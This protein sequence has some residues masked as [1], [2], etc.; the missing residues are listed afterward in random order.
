METVLL[1]LLGILVIVAGFAISI[2]LHEV[3]H[4]V[5]A[6]L[7]GVKVTQ[8]MIGFG[9]TLFSRKAGETEYGVKAVP[10]GGYIAMIGMYPPIEGEK[11]RSGSTGFFQTLMQDARD[12]SKDQIAGDD[13]RT[14]Y[15]LP[16][17]KKVIVM[18]GGP[19]M[20][21][22]LGILFYA[23]LFVGI[24][25]PTAATTTIQAVN[26]C[27]IVDG[28]DRTT[29]TD[30]DPVAPALAGGIEP[31]DRVVA[32]DGQR[33]TGWDQLSELIREN[34][35]DTVSMTVVRDGEEMQLQVTPMT[36]ARIVYDEQTGE[37]VIGA[38]GQPETEQVGFLGIVPTAA[39][40]PQPVTSVLPA[41]GQNI[42]QVAGIIVNLPQR[43][44]DTAVAAF[45]GGERD[46]E[47]PVSVIGVGRLAGEI[48]AS[49]TL[50]WTDRIA[51]L[52]GILAALNIGLAIFNLIPLPPL[53]GGHVIVALWEGL[54][55]GIAKLFR[56]PPP[57]PF[58]TAKLI[59]V[60]F[61][62]VLLFGGMSLLLFYADIVN[63][64]NLLG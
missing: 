51:T 4:L 32:F 23:I 59:P 5:P 43:L 40:E 50:D 18:L 27:V 25:L 48:T 13:D 28:S 42:A 58:D 53:D 24:G 8:Y 9:R 31:G 44:A 14:F 60:T 2:G 54:R 22:L 35:D 15:R 3:G 29:C 7:F 47:G 36:T 16:V 49:A 57:R 56:R 10:L 46:P 63:P 19:A 64:I 34:G 45:G 37:P 38:D 20:N 41:V 55:K 21:I 33:I 17:W 12:M 62:A 61:V 30:T 26:Q 39:R 6:K 1:Y 52:I 11:A